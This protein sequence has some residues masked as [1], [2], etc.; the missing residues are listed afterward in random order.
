MSCG[1]TQGDHSLHAAGVGDSAGSN[2]G[3]LDHA[4]DL[5]DERESADLRAQILGQED[6][7]M[8]T[9]FIAL[10]DDRVHAAGFEISRLIQCRRRRED[11]RTPDL[12]ALDQ[13]S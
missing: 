8:A 12:D 3:H 4:G 10:R 13:R 1:R 5:L 9:G 11:L 2:D 6:A 7:A